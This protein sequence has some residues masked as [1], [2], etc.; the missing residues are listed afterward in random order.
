[1]LHLFP[2]LLIPFAVLGGAFYV[3]RQTITWKEFV[4]LEV[5]MIVLLV[6]GFFWA[7]WGSMRSVEHWNGH[8]TEKIEDSISCC[9]CHRVCDSKD[10]NGNCT[11]DHEV[12]SHSSDTE[13]ALAISTGDRVVIETCDGGFSAPSAWKAAKVGEFAAVEH[14][15]TNYL[16]ADPDALILHG[17]DAHLLKA[18]PEFPEIHDFYRVSK[19]VT[20]G[21]SAPAMWQQE[22]EKLNDELGSS[23]QIDVTFL[24]TKNPNANDYA[25]AVESA[26]MY[27]P[28]N[29]L[30]VVI[31]TDGETISWARVVTLSRVEELKIEIREGLKGL[32]L[33]DPTI[34]K[35]IRE[36]IQKLWHRTAMA[37]WEYLAS[38]ASPSTGA[39]VFLY[40]FGIAL[41]IGFTALA[42]H[43]D[44][45][46]DE[47]FLNRYS[48]F[49]SRW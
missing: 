5:L 24:L 8:I 29:A 22:L 17:A 48:R 20:D 9:H 26:W 10:K 34:F 28:K 3:L 15:Y 19:V 41:S 35:V 46:G 38:H 45:F 7:R 37:E 12:C 18:V 13:W 21:A 42:H 49:R 39:L 16:K 32:S 40:I 36:H 25:A 23:K 31:G 2:L 33:K 27:G 43:K 11:S 1:M 6:G 44:L 14:S 47:G 4:A 30:I